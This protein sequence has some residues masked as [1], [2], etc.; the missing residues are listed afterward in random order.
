M[1]LNCPFLL[2][3]VRSLDILNLLHVGMCWV[4]SFH[5]DPFSFFLTAIKSNGTLQLDLRFE[6]MHSTSASI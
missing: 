1:Y 6:R 4:P 5:L 3:L 2:C